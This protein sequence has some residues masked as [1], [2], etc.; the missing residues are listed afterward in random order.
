MRKILLLLLLVPALAFG[1]TNNFKWVLQ[2]TY[3]ASGTD[4][5]TASIPGLTAYGVGLEVKILFTNSN[6]AS[7]TLQIGSLAVIT[8]KKNGSTNL[9]PGDIPAGATLKLS[10]DGTNFQ[11]LGLGGSG[12]VTSVTGTTNRITSTGGLTPVIDISGSYVG[13]TSITTLGTIGTGTWNGTVIGSAYGGAGAISGLLKANGSG[14]VSAATAGTDYLTPSGSGSSLT[15]VWL[16]ASGVTLTGANTITATGTN[17]V[18]FNYATLG[19]NTGFLINSNASDAASNTGTVFKVTKTGANASQT[20]YGIYS[21]NTSTG[22]SS[23]NIA[24]Y[25]EAS[26]GANNH[27]IQIGVG[28]L[29]LPNATFFSTSTQTEILVTGGNISA[30]NGTA[31][32]IYNVTNITSQGTFSWLASNWAPASGTV[33]MTGLR[34]GQTVSPTGGTNHTYIGLDIN[35]TGTFSNVGTSIALR[36]TFGS[37]FLANSS[38]DTPTASTRL[39]VRGI[40]GGTLIIRAATSGNSDVFSVSD[41]N[42]MLGANGTG[43]GN[44]NFGG[45][46]NLG[47]MYTTNAGNLQTFANLSLS[48]YN[49]AT[50][51]AAVTITGNLGEL[52]R[53]VLIGSVSNNARLYVS[54]QVLTAGWIPSLRVDAGAHT[55]LTAATAFPNQVFSSATQTWV[56]VAGTIASQK[57]TEF[58]AIT[59]SAAT[60]GTFTD[61]YN[62]FMEAPLVGG[63]ATATN[64]YA[65]GTSGHIALTNSGT[66]SE[67]R[68]LEPSAG[69]SSYVGFK[70]PALAGNIIFTLPPAFVAGGV[71]TDVAGDG[72]LTMV[73]PSG[74]GN[75]SKVGTPVNDQIGVWTGDGTIE[76]TLGLTYSGTNLQLTGDIGSTGTRITKGWFTDLEVTNAISGSITGNAA[77]VTTNANLTG[78]ITSTGNAAIL[79]SFTIAN[80]STA[81]SDAN[82]AGNNLGDQTITNSSDATSHTVTLSSSGGTV[83]LIEGANITL[84]TGG[85]GSAGTVT[86]ASTGGGITNGA[87]AN[88]L[89]KSDGTD[90]VASGIFS[91]S[92]ADVQFGTGLTGATRTLSANGSA[93]DVSLSLTAKGAGIVTIATAGGWA[94]SGFNYS[95]AAGTSPTNSITGNP[96]SGTAVLA[97]PLSILGGNTAATAASTSGSINIIAGQGFGTNSSSGSVSIGTGG[98]TGSG[99]EGSVDIQNRSTGKL[100]FFNATAVVKQSSVTTS[101]GI[102]D[103]LTAYGLLPSSTISSGSGLTYAESKALSYKFK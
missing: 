42:T 38:G 40:S 44:L 8:L 1:Q 39:D 94:L 98:I 79:G 36:T 45:N 56:A 58:R 17:N 99:T 102:A 51:G 85:T 84:T 53:N 92:L 60:S 22:A 29:K 41:T 31:F 47:L 55:A 71:P 100:G 90:A 30:A 86:I 6:T 59:H 81:I 52:S 101:Q 5:Y 62:V 11:V 87:A 66:A 70:A 37:T 32:L 15:G 65:I 3:T 54:Q 82:I 12:A 21:S 97:G 18:T 95:T 76:G 19:A 35:S 16:A 77:T 27:A 103:V 63:A 43:T 34:V 88:E 57:D 83:Q 23:I 28:N 74:S 93:S 24:G 9:S 75:V 89:M 80:L 13:Q 61:L 67:L 25:F 2:S 4:T 50:Y 73:V 48:T 26:G 10:Y 96:I 72:V 14:T 33:T 46:T 68:F 20:T 49:G 91:S 7:S 64:R 78:H 69:G